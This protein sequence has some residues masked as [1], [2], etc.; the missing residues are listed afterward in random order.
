MKSNFMR[1]RWVR[2]SVWAMMT[3]IAVSAIV[4]GVAHRYLSRPYPAKVVGLGPILQVWWSDG[5]SSQLNATPDNIRVFAVRE[6]TT[7]GPILQIVRHDGH[8]SFHLI[9]T[10]RQYVERPE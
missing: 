10:P 5:T 1:F 9:R 7:H 6:I 2:F 8:R 3:S 4:G